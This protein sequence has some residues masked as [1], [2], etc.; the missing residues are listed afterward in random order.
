VNEGATPNKSRTNARATNSIERKRR[1]RKRKQ[2]RWPT[3]EGRGGTYAIGH[4]KTLKKKVGVKGKPSDNLGED[5]REKAGPD[6]TKKK[7]KK[8]LKDQGI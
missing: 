3:V 8:R 5:F 4:C 6:R 2:A 1:E 7:K